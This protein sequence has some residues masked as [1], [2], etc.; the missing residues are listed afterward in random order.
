ML[1]ISE[2]KAR[3]AARTE[4]TLADVRTVYADL[5][6]YANRNSTGGPAT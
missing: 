1:K 4:E 2:M 6:N 5:W 3:I